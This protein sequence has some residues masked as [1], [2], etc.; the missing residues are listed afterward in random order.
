MQ[1]NACHE[2]ILC[3]LQEFLTATTEIPSY[4]YR[5]M[6]KKFDAANFH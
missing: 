6:N 4:V 5:K 3:F 1:R 2:I